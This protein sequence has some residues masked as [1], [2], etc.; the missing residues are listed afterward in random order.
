MYKAGVISGRFR[1]LH[2]AH[3]E[4]ITR[5]TLENIEKL[6]IVI[7]DSPDIKRYSTI[8]ELRIA[9][10][11]MLKGIDMPYQILISNIDYQDTKQFE[12]YIIEAIGHDNILMF[13]S[14][15]TYP[16]K[17]VDNKFINC[18]SSINISSSQIEANPYRIDNYENIAKEFMPYINKK[19]VLSGLESSGKTQFCI[20]LANVFNTTFSGEVGRYY[21]SDNLGGD[22]EAFTPKDFVFIAMDQLNQD[23]KMNQEA[24]RC[25]F[26]DTD[27]I[28]TKRF[29]YAYYEEYTQRGLIDDNFKKEYDDAMTM[30]DTLCKTYRCDHVFVLSPEVEYVDDGLRWQQSDEQKAARFKLLL[31]LYDEYNIEYTIINGKTYQE[32]FHSIEQHLEQLMQV[33][34]HSLI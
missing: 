22:D 24:K 11:N 10:G 16:N 25:L 29:L 1:L 8:S 33:T 30:L 14:K 17:L 20:K 18:V 2:K 12:E 31:D 6:Y 9:I 3:K 32:R 27:P 7:I 4:V 21:G 15:D 26:V 34:G 19:I 5:A 28:V 13:D 23:K